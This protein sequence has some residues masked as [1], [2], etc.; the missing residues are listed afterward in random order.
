VTGALNVTAPEPVQNTEFTKTLGRVLHRPTLF[1]VPAV[2][3]KLRF[4][5]FAN[6]L[7]VSQRVLPEKTQAAGYQFRYTTLEP[8]LRACLR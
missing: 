5:E 3:L 4:G 7:V 1:P 6:F 2:A 8:A